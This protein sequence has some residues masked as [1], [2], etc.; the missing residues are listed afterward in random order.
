MTFKGR[1]IIVTGVLTRHSIAYAIAEKLITLDAE[2]TLTGF[3][4]TRRM[5]ERAARGLSR[6]VEVLE[7]DVSDETSIAAFAREVAAG[8]S[9]LHGLV[10]SIAHA[11][12]DALGGRFVDT[13]Q[14]AALHALRV[15][16]VSLQ[17]LASALRPLLAKSGRSSVVAMD[18]DSGRVWPGYDWMG[19]AKQTLLSVCRHLSVYLGGDGIRVNVIASG[20]LSTPAASAVPGFGFMGDA[21]SRVAPLGWD[22]EDASPIAEAASFL[23]SDASRCITGER[24][25]VDG[26]AHAIAAVP[27]PDVNPAMEPAFVPQEDLMELSDDAVPA[28][29]NGDNT[30]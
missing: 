26:G 1:R 27:L 13:G 3:G 8:G 12:E 22:V 6:P 23:L 21:W 11:G 15:S 16:A 28:S 9:V 5:T 2:V 17:S 29:V 25:H 24:L 14:E 18:F 30:R 4:R 7:L 19:V 10:H 20:P